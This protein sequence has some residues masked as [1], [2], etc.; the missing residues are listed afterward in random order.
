M[1]ISPKRFTRRD[2]SLGVMSHKQFTQRGLRK[3]LQ[4][5]VPKIQTGLNLWD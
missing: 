1:D 4:G 5:L 3:K 2:W